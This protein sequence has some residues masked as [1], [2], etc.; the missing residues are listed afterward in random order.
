MDQLQK[1]GE[2]AT[3][4]GIDQ[5][6]ARVRL[7]DDAERRLSL[8]GETYRGSPFDDYADPWR[9]PK[10]SGAY[11]CEAPRRGSYGRLTSIPR[12]GLFC[13]EGDRTPPFR[14]FAVM[15]SNAG[16]RAATITDAMIA[17]ECKR[18]FTPI[19]RCYPRRIPLTR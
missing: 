11:P 18:L 4:V 15:F 3:S 7:S 1:A 6:R 8:R 2:P 16:G 5:N 10:P 13:P 14:H 19:T 9:A 12:S 17:E